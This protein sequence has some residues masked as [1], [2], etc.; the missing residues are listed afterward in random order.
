MIRFLLVSLI[1][2]LLPQFISAESHR[3][4]EVVHYSEALQKRVPYAIYIPEIQSP[5]ERFP[6]VYVLH[7]YGNTY[8]TAFDELQADLTAERTE[9]IV[10]FVEGGKSWYADSL[11][12]SESHYE[13][14]IINDLIPEIDALFPTVAKPEAR[15]ICGW[16]MG[17]NGALILAARN[18][19]VFGVASAMSGIYDL[20][21]HTDAWG[22]VQALGADFESNPDQWKSHSA[23]Y[24]VD[25]LI[26]QQTKLLFDVGTVDVGTKALEHGRALHALLTEKDAP[27]IYREIPGNHNGDYWRAQIAEHLNF[28]Q[29]MMVE[30]V[31]N[32]KSYEQHCYERL[33]LFAEENADPS[34]DI[35][36]M[37]AMKKSVMLLGSSS[38]EAFPAELLPGFRIINRGIGSDVL[39][40]N[41]RGLLRHIELSIFDQHP[42]VI[43]FQMGVN[44]LGDMARTGT[45]EFEEI[46]AAYCRVIEAI[47][48]RRPEV[49]LILQRVTPVTG[50]FAHLAESV[51]RYN[52]ELEAIAKKY[53][54]LLVDNHT[55]FRNAEGLLKEEFTKDGLHL[56]EEGMKLWAGIL[57]QGLQQK[58]FLPFHS[59]AMKM[60]P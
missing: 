28:H 50:R 46:P 57:A 15:G 26:E 51:D 34:P 42:D 39:G 48:S 35:D 60:T 47:R 2:L 44:D 19:G 31:P 52:L 22:V 4:R 23:F 11:T 40:I 16:S 12:D 30:Y 41:R 7:G 45:P 3:L 55:P 36:P 59:A 10:V 17:G 58:G 18:P 6:V 32:L 8:R 49:T 38:S 14:Y 56:N 20:S 5:D 54:L 33:K 53:D 1:A 24:L 37:E 27:H 25:Q 29:A 13:S 21:Q 9:L 43:L